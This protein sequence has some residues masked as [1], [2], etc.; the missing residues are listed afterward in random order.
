MGN[1]EYAAPSPEILGAVPWSRQRVLARG[2][3]KRLGSVAVAGFGIEVIY[4]LAT[5]GPF[6][7][8]VHGGKLVDL[9]ELSGHRDSAGI[10]VALG[11]VGLFALYGFALD[12]LRRARAPSFP[13]VFLGTIGFSLTLVFLYPVTAMDVYNYAVQG[14]VVTFHG[15]NPLVTAPA[16]VQG[17]SFISYGGVWAES[18]SPYG[19]VWI[20]VSALDSLIA[21][22][23]VVRAVVILK[24]ISA[25]GVVATTLLLARGA[26]RAKLPRPAL[27]AA[28]FGW[29]PLVQLELVGNGHN[30]SIMIALFVLSLLLVGRRGARGAFA[31]AAS[32]FVKYLT[33]IALPFYLLA[34]LRGPDAGDWRGWRRRLPA[35]LASVGVFAITA[36]LAYAPF[37]AGPV[38]LARVR[39]VDQNY[40]ASMSALALLYLPNASAWLLTGRVA[41]VAMIAAWQLRSFALGRADVPRAVFEVYFGVLLI[42]THFA[43]WYLPLLV[44]LGVLS[45]DRWLIS[46]AVVFSL[47]A[48]LTV[49]L[50]QYL[51]P[52]VQNSAG[53]GPFHLLIVPL[54]FLPPLII[55]ALGAARSSER[56]E[57]T[58]SRRE[59][60]RLDR[61]AAEPIPT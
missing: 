19:P 43:G 33:V 4:L 1:V 60:S 23:D 37:W 61:S 15:I 17:D 42:A 26:E 32:V 54:T 59:V 36:V 50:W 3:G 10:L 21:G 9:G 49:P 58:G 53:L 20:G 57:R 44:A 24:S 27:A 11:I 25:L 55:A 52:Q 6:S 7:L 13:L 40:L 56:P 14:H 2:R 5:L 34:E 18:T 48:I 16:T 39:T 30:D 45:A 28:I 12:R 47:S 38:T 31:L 46:R 22:A 35:V 51:W 41:V 8:L 29:N